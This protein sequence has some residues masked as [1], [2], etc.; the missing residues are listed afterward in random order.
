[1]WRV[2]PLSDVCSDGI[3]VDYNYYGFRCY[4]VFYSSICGRVV[5]VSLV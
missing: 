2:Y 4:S 1:V 5:A 3:E